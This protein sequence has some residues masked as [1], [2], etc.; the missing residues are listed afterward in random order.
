VISF[1]DLDVQDPFRSHVARVSS[2]SADSEEPLPSAGLVLARF[3]ISWALRRFD[4]SCM[5]L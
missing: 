2:S 3:G 1:V 5:L 4:G